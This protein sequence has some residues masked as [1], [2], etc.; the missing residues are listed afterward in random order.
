MILHRAY[1]GEGMPFRQALGLQS[2]PAAKSMTL[3]ESFQTV[4]KY[5]G[6][7][8]NDIPGPRSRMRRSAI[9]GDQPSLRK[10]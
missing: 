8:L 3:G 2:C 7:N 9:Q 10:P 6:I 1:W 4:C 5:D